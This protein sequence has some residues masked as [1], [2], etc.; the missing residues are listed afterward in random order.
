M[1]QKGFV[2]TSF[3]EGRGPSLA[4]V[5]VVKSQAARLET[6]KEIPTPANW[7]GIVV[8]RETDLN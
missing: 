5:T 2:E 7:E 6:E 4:C 1:R 3:S 8:Y